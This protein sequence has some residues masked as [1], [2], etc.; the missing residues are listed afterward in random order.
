MLNVNASFKTNS[1]T[2]SSLHQILSFN[3]QYVTLYKE[4]T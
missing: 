4:F 2:F 1:P 3:K